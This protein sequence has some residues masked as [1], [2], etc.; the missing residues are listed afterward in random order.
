MRFE[1][2]LAKRTGEAS[3][4]K[5][6]F[7]LFANRNL[8]ND[9]SYSWKIPMVAYFPGSVSGLAPGSEVTMHGLAVG[10]VTDVRLAYDATKDSVLAPVRFEV[11]P[12]RVLGIGKR[13]FDTPA[14]GIDQLVKQGLRATLQTANL[15]TG[16]QVVALDFVSN[17]LPATVTMAGEDF[18]LPTAD[19]GGL[20]DLGTS[21]TGLISKVSTIPFDQIGKNLDD[22]L[23]AVNDIANGAQL[24]Q[25]LTDLGSAIKSADNVIQHLDSNMNPALRLLPAIAADAQRT[26]ANA[27]RLIVSLNS[28]YGDN[29]QVNRDLARLLVQ[30]N[31]AMRAIRLLADL[32]ARHPEALIKGRPPGGLE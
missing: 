16:Q 28:G 5:H 32:L 15:I 9:A 23:Q 7:P 18:V 21:V 12:E 25:S 1:T 2:P 22:I 17:P 3:A 26:M 20:A 14:E 13:A 29:T 27:N 19:S 24:R 6:V 4:E 10:R 31:D 30:T 11:E 8:T